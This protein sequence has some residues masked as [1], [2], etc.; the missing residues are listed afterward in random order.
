MP[1]PTSSLSDYRRLISSRSVVVTVFGADWCEPCQALAP[2]LE[3]I[4][5]QFPS[6]LFVR[7]DVER[8]EEIAAN[9]RVRGLPTLTFHVDGQR[10][11]ASTIQGAEAPRLF[12]TLS[13][14]TR[15]CDYGDAA[16]QPIQAQQQQAFQP[17]QQQTQAFQSAAQPPSGLKS[18][19]R[20]VLFEKPQGA[21]A[22]GQAPGQSAQ[23][24]SHVVEVQSMQ[25][26]TQEVSA[27]SGLVVIDFNATWCMP[28]R[29]IAPFF[30]HL[31]QTYGHVKFL[32]VDVDRCPDLAAAMEI[33]RL[34]TFMIGAQGAQKECFEGSDTSYLEGRIRFWSVN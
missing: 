9:Q 33:K 1:T 7:V 18:R 24:E 21:P 34:P 31:A 14:L 12:H 20:Q 10:L 8:A 29:Q 23:E 2:Q 15:T 13:N 28:C 5:R 4:E 30:R 17:T 16:P 25:H 11:E 3:I 6:V 22:Q 19:R 27:A 26:Y 32:S